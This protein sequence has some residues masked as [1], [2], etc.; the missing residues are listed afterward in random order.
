MSVGF[1]YPVQSKTKNISF[2]R[3][4]CSSSFQDRMATLRDCTLIKRLS[5]DLFKGNESD[6]DLFYGFGLEPF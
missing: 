2:K 3:S 6:Y 5:N 1:S 4:P